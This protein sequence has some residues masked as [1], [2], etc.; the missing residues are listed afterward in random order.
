RRV[1]EPLSRMG[2]E[3]LEARDG[4]YP[5]LRVRGRR[6]LAALSYRSPVASAQVK[7]AILLAGL[8]ADG[9]TRVE[10]PGLSRDHTER[11]LAWLGRPPAARP[12]HVPGDLSSAAF[13]LAAALLVPGSAVTVEDV[14]V[15]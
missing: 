7:S 4:T 14:G 6:P 15:N 3:V 13:M 9:E 5:P 12:I 2:L 1:L 10:E 8:Y 11:M